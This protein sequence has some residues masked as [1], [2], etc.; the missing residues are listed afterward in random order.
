MMPIEMHYSWIPFA[1]QAAGGP[2]FATALRQAA[3][4]EEV[5]KGGN[6]KI[7]EAQL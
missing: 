7:I 6:C 3:Q 1:H 2:S 4:I 5:A